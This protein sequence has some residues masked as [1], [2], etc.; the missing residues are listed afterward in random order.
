MRNNVDASL[1]NQ[2]TK[3]KEIK[4]AKL[5]VSKKM[6]NKKETKKKMILKSIE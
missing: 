4:K 6:R 2:K 1:K 3:L 5:Q